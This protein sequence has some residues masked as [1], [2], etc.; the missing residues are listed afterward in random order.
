MSD[1]RPASVS[2]RPARPEDCAGICAAH[3]ASIRDICSRDYT[4]EEVESWCAGKTPET[5]A[6]LIQQ[7]RWLVA[8]LGGRIVGFGELDPAVTPRTAEIRGLYLAPEAVGRG[9]GRDLVERLLAMARAAGARRMI[10]KGTLTAE[11]FYQ[12]MGFRTVER[13]THRSRGGLDLACVAME[14]A[15]E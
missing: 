15:L 3:L 2:I 8:E 6:P 4:P 10:L 7:Y 13:T 12:R 14:M 1:P 9:I 5:Y 11:A